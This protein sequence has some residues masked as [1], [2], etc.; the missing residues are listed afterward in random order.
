M[1]RGKR[2]PARTMPPERRKTALIAWQ[3]GAMTQILDPPRRRRMMVRRRVPETAPAPAPADD[4]PLAPRLS[5]AAA[6]AFM[7][8]DGAGEGAGG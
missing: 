7:A 3:A 8:R 4:P 1:E 5:V 2:P 6:R